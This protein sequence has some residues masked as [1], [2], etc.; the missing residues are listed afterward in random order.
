M[1]Y[2]SITTKVREYK[3]I[4]LQLV[5]ATT[6]FGLGFG[7][8]REWKSQ[9]KIELRRQAKYTTKPTETKKAE[10]QAPTKTEGDTKPAE[11]TK[12][13]TSATTKESKAA[14]PAA[15]APCIIKGNINAKGE[16]LYHTKASPVY[17][18]TKPEACFATEAEA[19]AAGFKKSK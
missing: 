4:L 19:V 3:P 5:V 15:D 9:E 2:E 13:K 8:G 11:P 18:R 12:E 7:S 17:T 16:K 6:M 1:T 10:A 14:K